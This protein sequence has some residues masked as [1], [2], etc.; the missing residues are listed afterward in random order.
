MSCTRMSPKNFLSRELRWIGMWLPSFWKLGGLKRVT[1]RNWG[2]RNY[3]R[4]FSLFF[5][6]TICHR[7]CVVRSM[8]DSSV[9]YYSSSTFAGIVPMERISIGVNDSLGDGGGSIG[10]RGA[11][12]SFVD[13]GSRVIGLDKIWLEVSDV[14]SSIGEGVATLD[15]VSDNVATS[16]ETAWSSDEPTGFGHVS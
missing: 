10:G 7:D 14:P 3:L 15:V 6:K 16:S 2:L 13:D 5:F 9:L 12:S 8:I 11:I 4:H 1:L